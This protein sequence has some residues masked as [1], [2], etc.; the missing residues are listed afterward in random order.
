[1]GK[2]LRILHYWNGTYTKLTLEEGKPVTLYAYQDT[3]EGWN[4]DEERIMLHADG[5][6]TLEHTNDGRDCDGRLTR[7]TNYVMDGLTRI[8][9]ERE[10]TAIML[11]ARVQVSES[12]MVPYWKPV[13]GGQY[14]EFAQAAGY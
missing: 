2:K 7:S 8:E 13:S 11:K 5:K 6:V 14:D 3:E 9:V 1:M 10:P 12:F 4:S